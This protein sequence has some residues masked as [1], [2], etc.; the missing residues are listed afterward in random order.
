VR[1]AT[2]HD[3][4]EIQRISTAT[5]Q[6]ESDSGADA[7]YV[8]HVLAV[9]SAVVAEADGRVRGWAAITFPGP[10]SM[11]SDLFVE[12]QAQGRGIGSALL[13]ALWPPAA[14]PARFT[15][16]SSHP[17]A[18]ATY[19]RAGLVPR[20]ALLYLTGPQI[21]A[22]G[23][24]TTAVRVRPAEAVAAER[25]LTGA[26]RHDDYRYW[27]AHLGA[28]AFV[29]LS[30]GELVAAG[31]RTPT[32]VIHQVCR[33]SADPI[34]AVRASL[35][36]QPPSGAVQICLP[37]PHPAVPVLAA[38]GYRVVEHDIAMATEPVILPVTNVYSSGLG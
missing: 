2:E 20:W 22:S 21:P 12:P 30:D 9:G 6:P 34:S 17:A 1:V 25:D 15:F 23:G 13:A 18:R 11:L 19:L 32:R 16:S 37:E 35:A 24:S 3:V 29:V 26:D 38:V 36:T 14:P 10:G 33:T 27:T 4:P 31:A 7:A 5:G 28:E 8:R